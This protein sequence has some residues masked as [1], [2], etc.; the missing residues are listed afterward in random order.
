[1]IEFIEKLPEGL[2]AALTSDHAAIDGEAQV[3]KFVLAGVKLTLDS[4]ELAYTACLDHDIFNRI[5]TDLEGQEG[6]LYITADRVH[7]MNGEKGLGLSFDMP[8][9]VMHAFQNP[10][11]DQGKD[12]WEVLAMVDGG[13]L[14]M[15][16]GTKLLEESI[17]LED[18]DE[19][20]D[21]YTWNLWFS[22]G[23][24]AVADSIDKVLNECSPDS[25]AFSDEEDF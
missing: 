24:K 12:E 17:D 6:T 11:K 14:L 15:P 16:D 5:R 4:G 13:Q 25:G 3:V 1:M 20:I 21:C 7:W 22:V 2:T 19:E 23:P 9:I 10:K 8:S 18:Y